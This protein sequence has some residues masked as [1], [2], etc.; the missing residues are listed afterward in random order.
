MSL[1]L[2][3]RDLAILQTL[4]HK[5]Q[6]PKT[7]NKS[8]TRE[9]MAQVASVLRREDAGKLLRTHRVRFVMGA[10]DREV[11]EAAATKA[12]TSITNV[13][14]E[15]LAKLAREKSHLHSGIR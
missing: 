15:V 6:M 8:T 1:R 7:L 13:V 11:I 3:K 2:T 4:R 12:G 5:P 9:L 10:E 14:M